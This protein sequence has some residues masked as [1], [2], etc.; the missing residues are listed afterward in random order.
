MPSTKLSKMPVMAILYALMG[1]ALC[2]CG[3]TPKVQQLLLHPEF[4]AAAQFAPHFTAEALKAI[5]DYE[6]KS[7]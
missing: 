1:L 5:A 2:G 3:T 7:W 4:P 6:R